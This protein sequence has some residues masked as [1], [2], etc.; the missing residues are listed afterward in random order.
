MN[1]AQCVQVSVGVGR[2]AIQRDA[3]QQQITTRSR[4]RWVDCL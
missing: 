4:Y 1:C 3:L 2:G